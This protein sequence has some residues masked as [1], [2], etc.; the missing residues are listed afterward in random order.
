[1]KKMWFFSVTI[2]I[3]IGIELLAA[4]IVVIIPKCQQERVMAGEETT[5]VAMDCDIAL[6]GGSM[7]WDSSE[8]SI[9][10]V[11]GN[12]QSNQLLVGSIEVIYLGRIVFLAN[13]GRAAPGDGLAIVSKPFSAQRLRTFAEIGRAAPGDGIASLGT[14]IIN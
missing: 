11:T 2:S 14:E 6:I 4:D 7:V 1:M 8:S 13:I 3:L 9:I 10:R 5:I 12:T